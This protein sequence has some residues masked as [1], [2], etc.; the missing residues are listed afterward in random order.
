MYGEDV[1]LSFKAC[2]AGYA[3]YYL[4][5]VEIVHHGGGSTQRRF[6]RFGDVM[7]RESVY[8]FMRKTAGRSTAVAYRLSLACSA[9]LRLALVLVSL[10]VAAPAGRAGACVLVLR[11]WWAILRWALGAERW[12]HDFDLP[13]LAVAADRG[14]RAEPAPGNETRRPRPS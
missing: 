9:V 5:T 7:T 14:P 3:N 11:K 6:N 8:C 1:D 13:K 2:A 12:V 10:L 4:R